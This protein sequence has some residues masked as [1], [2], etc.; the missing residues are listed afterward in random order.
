MP[1]RSRRAAARAAAERRLLEL[2]ADVL[3]LVLYQLLLAHEAIDYDVTWP[4]DYGFAYGECFSSRKKEAEALKA[5]AEF[6]MQTGTV[7]ESKASD[8]RMCFFF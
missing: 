7:G 4:E 3:G 6:G 8:A 2:P 1:T 5:T